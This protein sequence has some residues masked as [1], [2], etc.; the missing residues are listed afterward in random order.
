MPDEKKIVYPKLSYKIIG[1]AYEV[2][3]EIGFGKEE[4]YYQ[5]AFEIVLKDKK[6]RYER[7]KTIPI[8]FKEKSIGRY[9]LDFVVEDKIVVELKVRPCLGYVHIKQTMNYLK[10]A[11]YKLA[12]LIYFTKTGVKFRRIINLK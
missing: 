10:S 9:F 4:K 12:I 11:N 7:E 8:K 6:L 1:I 3:N 2:F 5:R